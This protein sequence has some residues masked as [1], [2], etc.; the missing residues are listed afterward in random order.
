MGSG[1]NQFHL[2][3]SGDEKFALLDD[4]CM[5][6]IPGVEEVFH[7]GPAIG[8]P[9]DLPPEQQSVSVT[10][11]EAARW[12]RLYGLFSASMV[13]LQEQAAEERKMFAEKM[14]EI[15]RRRQEAWARYETISNT[16]K[17]NRS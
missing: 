3:A 9:A 12:P 14:A 6:L 8:D 4:D 7:L 1:N 13:R 16:I 10:S 15:D 11:D 17:E 5:T 2:V